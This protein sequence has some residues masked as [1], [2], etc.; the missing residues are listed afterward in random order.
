MADPPVARRHT[1][2]VD[3]LRAIPVPNLMTLM[4]NELKTCREAIIAGDLIREDGSR[5]QRFGVVFM[6]HLDQVI[7][8]ATQEMSQ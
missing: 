5:V 3:E 1:W 2:M 6:D 8:Q 4:L 7:E